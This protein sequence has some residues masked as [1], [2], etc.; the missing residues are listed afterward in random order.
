M[1]QENTGETG[2][3]GSVCLTLYS[4][5]YSLKYF[6]EYTEIYFSKYKEYIFFKFDINFKL[7]TLHDLT[8]LYSKENYKVFLKYVNYKVFLKYVNYVNLYHLGKYKKQ[9]K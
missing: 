7:S 4:L 9:L 5:K 6:L 8:C 2:E 3:R 1:K